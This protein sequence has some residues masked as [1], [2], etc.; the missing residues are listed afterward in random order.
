MADTD[1]GSVSDLSHSVRNRVYRDG[2]VVAQDVAFEQLVEFRDDKS[3]SIWVD[4]LE[5]SG[6]VLSQFMVRGAAQTRDDWS[7]SRTSLR[8]HRRWRSLSRR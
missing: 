4:L 6:E 8:V 5:P 2:K 3:T 1:G 7:H